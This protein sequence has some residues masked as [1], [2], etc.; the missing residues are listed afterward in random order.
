MLEGTLSA[1]VD[2]D[3]VEFSYTIE[4][5]GSNPI[6]AN[7]RDGQKFD[8]VVEA[9]GDEAWRWSHNRMFT[10]ALEEKTFSPGESVT[11]EATW[12][13]PDEGTYTATATCAANTHSARAT[14]TVEV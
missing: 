11:Y 13:N 3:A 10:M 4:N 12:D 7:Y 6:T 14:A 9:D 5:V 8:I 2:S 1:T